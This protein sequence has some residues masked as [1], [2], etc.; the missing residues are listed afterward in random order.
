MQSK[1]FVGSRCFWE[2]Y[3]CDLYGFHA[4]FDMYALLHQQNCCLYVEKH[5]V[6]N[7]NKRELRWS[8]HCGEK[9]VTT[10]MS[11]IIRM[12]FRCSDHH[13]S[14]RG[15]GCW[16]TALWPLWPQQPPCNLINLIWTCTGLITFTRRR[17]FKYHYKVLELRTFCLFYTSLAGP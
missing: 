12:C 10:G 15:Q 4:H 8:S 1:R 11:Y 17:R 14:C 5:H 9:V 6:N 16:C 2:R 7:W 13:L 3:S